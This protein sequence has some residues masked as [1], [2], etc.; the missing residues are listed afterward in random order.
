MMRQ[1]GSTSIESSLAAGPDALIASCASWRV[2][3]PVNLPP[4]RLR[5]LP[6]RGPNRGIADDH[7]AD[8]PAG[9][10]TD[11]CSSS[12]RISS[13]CAQEESGE[14]E[15]SCKRLSILPSTSGPTPIARP[16]ASPISPVTYLTRPRDPEAPDATR[17]TIRCY[18]R[19]VRP[20]LLGR[21]EY[22]GFWA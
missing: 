7:R 17:G 22:D 6:A 14:G 4:R 12:A 21:S 3:L 1:D 16:S 5:H 10:T 15:S 9:H 20:V 8:E 13:C 18:L 2:K 19:E 11:I